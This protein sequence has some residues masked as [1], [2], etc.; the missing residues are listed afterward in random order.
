[1]VDVLTDAN[2]EATASVSLPPATHGD[3]WDYGPNWLCGTTAAEGGL[4]AAWNQS[5]FTIYPA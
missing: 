2:G 1:M 3:D 5:L 4:T